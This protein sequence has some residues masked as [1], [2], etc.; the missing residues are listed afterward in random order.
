MNKKICSALLA[1][2]CLAP[3][4]YA[5][6][7]GIIY[8]TD[9]RDSSGRPVRILEKIKEDGTGRTQLISPDFRG[10]NFWP[11]YRGF[12]PNQFEYSDVSPQGIVIFTNTYNFFAISEKSNCT[13][14]I[15][16][17]FCKKK[18]VIGSMA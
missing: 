9:A 18:V 15:F 5:F 8:G 4:R 1:L 10:E 17:F 12:G 14:S 13:K 16:F 3:V 11:G 7:P 2:T 6:E